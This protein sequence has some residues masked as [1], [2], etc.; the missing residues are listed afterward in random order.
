MSSSTNVRLPGW[1]SEIGR[2]RYFAAYRR[3]RGLWE[4]P[5]EDVEIPGRFGVTHALVTGPSEGRPLF[6]LHSAFNIGAIQWYPNVG[7][8]AS[9]RRVVAL[10]FIGAPGLS[11]Q[12]SP[13]L[14]REDCAAWLEGVIDEFDSGGADL[15][16]SSHGGWLALNLAV[17]RPQRVRKLALLAP[18]AAL[19]PFRRGAVVSIRLGPF[20]PA[21][22]ARASLRPVFG[23]RHQVDDRL[24]ELLATS[25]RYYRFQEKAVFPDAFSDDELR[26]VAADTL[27][28]LGDKEII[29]DPRAALQRAEDLLASV[30][31]ELMANTGHLMNIERPEFVNSKLLAFLEAEK[32]AGLISR[33]VTPGSG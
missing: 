18:A 22:T 23:K 14:D 24:V 25:L 10:D 4:V 32:A 20:M 21:W 3:A 8:L 31:T 30:R 12:T 5:V 7:A 9:R 2:D 27:V 6:L 1:K 19:L 15:V 17:A 29:Y 16:G 33:P 28:L 11:R 13:I 26:S